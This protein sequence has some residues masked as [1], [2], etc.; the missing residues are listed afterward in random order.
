MPGLTGRRVLVTG[1]TGFIGGR[2]VE[3]LVLEHGARVRVLTSNYAGASRVSRFDVE[4]VRG[5]VAVADD[6]L[7]AAA[8]C[9][10]IFHCAYGSRGSDADRRRVTV[11]GTRAVLDAALA[12]RARV[13]HVSTMVV[14]GVGVAGRLDESA[15]RR[16]SGIGYADTKIEAERLAL[17]Y[18]T[19]RGLGVSVIQP[20]AV[21]GPYAPSWTVRV[22]TSLLT[23]RVV[24]V[25]GGVGHANP[26]YIDDVVDAMLLAA[27]RDEA[28][29]EAFLISS[30]ETVTWRE[31]YAAFEAML[32]VS[33]TVSMTSDEAKAHYAAAQRRRSVVPELL[34]LARDDKAVRARLAKTRELAALYGLLKP[35]ATSRLLGPLVSRAKPRARPAAAR[36]APEDQGRIAPVHPK[37]VDFLA[38]KTVVTPD[39]ARRLLGFEPA[40]DFPRGIDLTERWARWA[41]L[42]PD[43]EPT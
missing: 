33:A 4:L 32:G 35:L 20:T 43:G 23:G 18:A 15:P 25:D 1:G 40:F 3:K 31:F 28:Q 16:P 11:E 9:D 26:V 37:Q 5:D 27:E 17:S 22:L 7:H 14:Y 6:V 38:A 29:G 2:L 24:L 21:Y 19:E 36:R 42:L 34:A 13:V 10:A 30:G 12:H 39:K 8:G 41:N